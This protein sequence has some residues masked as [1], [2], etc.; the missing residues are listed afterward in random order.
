MKVPEGEINHVV[1]PSDKKSTEPDPDV[2]YTL[3]RRLVLGEETPLRDVDT[4][5]E[6]SDVE[7]SN[8]A[9]LADQSARL[10]YK[11][12]VVS[13]DDKLYRRH[14]FREHRSSNSLSK[15]SDVASPRP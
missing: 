14:T 7:S 12:L 11:L 9:R 13:S 5:E 1:A 3:V 2:S 15:A 4:I 8:E 10:G 6:L